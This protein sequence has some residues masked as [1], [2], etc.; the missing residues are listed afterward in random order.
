M[1]G[2][3]LAVRTGVPPRKPIRLEAKGLLC[4]PKTPWGPKSHL[5]HELFRLWTDP[6]SPRS[7]LG[8]EGAVV[9]DDLSMPAYEG[10]GFDDHEAVQ[11]LSLL[12]P[13][14]RQE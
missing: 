8:V 1:K 2:S 12:H 13:R 14:T 11:Q 5:Q 3:G 7:A 4:L 9:A 6:G 10:G